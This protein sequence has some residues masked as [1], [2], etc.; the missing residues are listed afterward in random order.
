MRK[1]KQHWERLAIQR[2]IPTPPESKIAACFDSLTRE[3]GRSLNV[4]G[5]NPKISKARTEI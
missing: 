4:S 3:L 1:Q 2:D 5:R